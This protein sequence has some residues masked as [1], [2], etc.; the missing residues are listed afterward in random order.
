LPKGHDRIV[1]PEAKNTMLPVAITP[2]AR[3]RPVIVLVET[4]ETA[5]GV[6]DVPVQDAPSLRNYTVCMHLSGTRSNINSKGIALAA[7][8]L[9]LQYSTIVYNKKPL[10]VASLSSKTGI[11]LRCNTHVQYDQPYPNVAN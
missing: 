1:I 11:H 5:A 10:A 3:V 6:D 2:I 7:M 8:L 4:A 9:L